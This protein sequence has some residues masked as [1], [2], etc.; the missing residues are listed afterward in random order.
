[1]KTTKKSEQ[2]SVWVKVGKG[3]LYF[4]MGLAVYV[5]IDHC[6]VDIKHAIADAWEESR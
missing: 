3:V 2:K 4:L 1:M 5:L 6:Y